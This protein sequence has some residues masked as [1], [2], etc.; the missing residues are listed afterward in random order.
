[1][2]KLVTTHLMAFWTRVRIFCESQNG[3]NCVLNTFT[4]LPYMW[5]FRTAQMK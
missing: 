4:I 2:S 1:M 3:E 5:E